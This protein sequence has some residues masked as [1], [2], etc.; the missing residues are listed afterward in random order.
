MKD[1]DETAFL[2]SLFMDFTSEN[3]L[4]LF[5]KSLDEVWSEDLYSRL[6]AAGLIRHVI[7]KVWNKEQHRISMVFEY[8]SK[9]GY[10]KCQKII[11]KKFGV[12]LKEKLKK[13]VFKIHNNRGIV[14]S[15]FIRSSS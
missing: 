3:E 1:T 6:S 15:E 8:D 10:Q 13:F 2:N 7:S 14:V 9:E 5:L 4:E 11:D 12:T